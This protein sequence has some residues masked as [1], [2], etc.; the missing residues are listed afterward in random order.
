MDSNEIDPI[1]RLLQA[2]IPHEQNKKKL[3]Q[4][5]SEL[6]IQEDLA[7]Q[8]VD[9]RMENEKLRGLLYFDHEQWLKKWNELWGNGILGMTYEECSDVLC[10]FH[11]QMK[12]RVQI[13]QH[14]P[15]AFIKAMQKAV[16]NAIKKRQEREE[17]N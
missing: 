1:T 7:L 4:M 6:N 11:G 13:G 9:L 8:I 16:A 12:T 14:S 2:S 17:G 5:R 10:F 3:N 15:E